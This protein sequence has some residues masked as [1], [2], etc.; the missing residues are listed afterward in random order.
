MRATPGPKNTEKGRR[1]VGFFS[2]GCLKI[3]SEVRKKSRK[4]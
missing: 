2:A 3:E 4:K 1:S